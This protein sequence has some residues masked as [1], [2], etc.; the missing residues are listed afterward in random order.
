MF[1][2]TLPAFPGNKPDVIE[3]QKRES[4]AGSFKV[5][6]EKAHRAVDDDYDDNGK[7]NYGKDLFHMFS[8]TLAPIKDEARFWRALFKN[9][10]G[11]GKSLE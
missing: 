11:L 4:Q 7:L 9:L 3:E 8:A 10:L 6:A 5:A 1:F 2:Q